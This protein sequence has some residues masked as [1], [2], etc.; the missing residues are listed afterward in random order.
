MIGFDT[1]FLTLMFIPDAAHPI[2][3][4]KARVEF[5]ISDIHG[6]G[7]KII[8]PTPA[9]AEILI[10]SGKARN[11]ILQEL[12]KSAKFT[13]APFDLRAALELSLLTDAAFT[14]KDKRSGATGTWVKLKYD[15]QII[16]ILKVAGA[17]VIYSED[18]DMRTVA[19]REGLKVVTVADIEI[20][21]P[22]QKDF[23]TPQ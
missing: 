23:W 13:I 7:D 22:A 2:S 18:S 16:A 6:R 4:A 10:K 11:Q 8:V 9:L 14:R 12:T 19:K 20:P 3:D 17:K 1:T 15:R 21:K 5:L